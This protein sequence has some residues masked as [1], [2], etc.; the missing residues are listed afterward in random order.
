M[1]INQLIRNLEWTR[2][3]VEE[4]TNLESEVRFAEEESDRLRKHFPFKD[5]TSPLKKRYWAIAIAGISFGPLLKIVLPPLRI[6]DDVILMGIYNQL[7][8]VEGD[9]MGGVDDV[10]YTFG[11]ALAPYVILMTAIRLLSN[12]LTKPSRLSKAYRN[13]SFVKKSNSRI[14][15]IYQELE[16]ETLIKS[17][18]HLN[19]E[20]LDFFLKAL[21]NGEANTYQECVQAYNAAQRTKEELGK[22][23]DEILSEISDSM[24]SSHD[25]YDSEFDSMRKEIKNLRADN[26]DLYYNR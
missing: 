7:N 5:W 8:P 25:Y 23:K 12:N 4:K 15:Y 17:E 24:N 14:D 16:N 3:L 18:E 11:L 10:F 26:D 13:D 22:I 6:F 2:K 9:F 21:K 19:L 1:E 20:A